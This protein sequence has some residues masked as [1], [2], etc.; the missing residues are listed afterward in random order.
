[1]T[2]TSTNTNSNANLN[3]VLDRRLG[4]PETGQNIATLSTITVPD[5]VLT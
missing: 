5:S 1:M 4:I 2:V 3:F